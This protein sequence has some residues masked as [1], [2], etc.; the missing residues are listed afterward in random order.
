MTTLQG[1]VEG[2]ERDLATQTEDSQ[3]AASQT[4]SQI[5]TLNA[6]LT[7]QME[8]SQTAASQMSSQI[9]TLNAELTSQMEESQTAA[10][11]M[12][13]QIEALNAELASQMEASQTVVTLQGII[14]V[15]APL[16]LLYSYIY[17]SKK[18]ISNIH[19]I[20]YAGLYQLPALHIYPRYLP[21]LTHLILCLFAA[22]SRVWKETLPRHWKTKSPWQKTR[23]LTR[24]K[25]TPRR[26][27]SWN[28][29][30][31]LRWRSGKRRRPRLRPSK[32]LL[33]GSSKS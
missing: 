17:T 12:S 30:S 7:S 21:F 3:T 32:A 9:E 15:G 6:E 2:L 23:K 14:E 10:S 26:W 22:L 18:C 20:N 28:S 5:E 27:P 4:S 29:V 33:K 11:Q 8:D 25:T 31:P 24:T 19:T 13:S 16:G 1:I